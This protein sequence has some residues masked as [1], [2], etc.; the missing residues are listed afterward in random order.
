M[1]KI[2]DHLNESLDYKII[3]VFL[4]LVYNPEK[5]KDVCETS[6]LI[7]TLVISLNTVFLDRIFRAVQGIQDS[8]KQ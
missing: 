8:H 3:S 4:K 7:E 5:L 6:L 1:V 2:L